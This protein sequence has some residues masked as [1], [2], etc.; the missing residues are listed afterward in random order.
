MLAG[1]MFG[2][3]LKPAT[4]STEDLCAAMLSDLWGRTCDLYLATIGGGAVGA[5]AIGWRMSGEP[6]AMPIQVHVMPAFRRRGIGRALLQCI[7]ALVEEE[8][9]SLTAFAM[10]EEASEAAAFA[11][12]CGFEEARRVQHFRMGP[13][14]IV[15]R[16][17][18]LAARFDAR[19]GARAYRVVPLTQAPLDQIALDVAR[20]FGGLQP[21]L[22]ELL[23]GSATA[24]TE[25][26]LDNSVAVLDGTRV[27]GA[28]ALIWKDEQPEVELDYVHPDYRGTAVHLL[29][30]L[31]AF[32]NGMAAGATS[33]TFRADDTV[34]DTLNIARRGGAT[35]IRTEVHMWR[36]VEKTVA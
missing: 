15:P 33:V 36:P 9:R 26:D 10:V 6:P 13:E 29:Q 31:A 17:R 8:A 3:E 4:R 14:V 21:E 28:L 30:L 34:R 2:L 25:I 32:E 7:E 20:T 12:A 19:T 22:L 11:T 1:R 35:P 23:R 24:A 16:L 18:A 5:A 27:A